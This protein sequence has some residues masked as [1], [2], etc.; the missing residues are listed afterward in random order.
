MRPKIV[1]ESQIGAMGFSSRVFIL[2]PA[3]VT[4]SNNDFCL[5]GGIPEVA[6]RDSSIYSHRNLPERL[7]LTSSGAAAPSLQTLHERKM[8][9]QYRAS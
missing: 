2:N 3:L 7:N 6:H 1:R 8:E 9:S 4:Q 5:R